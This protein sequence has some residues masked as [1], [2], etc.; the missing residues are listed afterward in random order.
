MKLKVV[1]CVFLLL[2]ASLVSGCTANSWIS[3]AG[4]VLQAK[5]KYEKDTRTK[6]IKA[7]NKAAGY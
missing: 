6:R 7:A 3:G 1:K 2:S 5:D 4:S